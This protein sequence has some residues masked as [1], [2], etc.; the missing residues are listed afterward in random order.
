MNES[1]D[2]LA[3]WRWLP[4]GYLLTVAIETPVLLAGLGWQRAQPGSRPERRYSL[5]QRLAAALWLTAVTYPVVTIGL[6]LLLWPVASYTTYFF[7][8]E[9]FAILVEC[10]LFRIVW[11]GSS[12]DLAVVALANI[13]SA[14]IGLLGT[15]YSL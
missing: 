8:A 4:A 12:R 10:L 15:A 3:L 14:A 6:P 11:R 2:A 5:R 7:V 9:G 13:A 1:V